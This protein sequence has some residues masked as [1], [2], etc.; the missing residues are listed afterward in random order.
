MSN[1]LTLRTMTAEEEQALG[2]LARSRIS[3]AQ[4]RD[5]ARIC[6]LASQG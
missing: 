5:R 3:Q 1:P 4:L 2:E 6:W